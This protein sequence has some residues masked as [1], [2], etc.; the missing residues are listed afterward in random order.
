MGLATHSP[1]TPFQ[2]ASQLIN[3]ADRLVQ[4]AKKSGRDRLMRHNSDSPVSAAKR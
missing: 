4:I 3:E 1:K 2:R